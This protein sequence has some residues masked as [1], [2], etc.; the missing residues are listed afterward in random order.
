MKNS[1][2]QRTLSNHISELFINR[3]NQA[4][5]AVVM[6]AQHFDV[7]HIQNEHPLQNVMRVVT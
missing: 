2:F 4:S 3:Y 1:Y 7:H 6:L 5:I